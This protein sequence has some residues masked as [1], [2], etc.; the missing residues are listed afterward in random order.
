MRK[1]AIFTDI[2]G[3]LEPLEAVLKNIKEKQ[4]DE[5][6]SLGDNIGVGPNSKEVM[7]LLKKNKVVS[8]AGNAEDYVALGIEPFSYIVG[9]KKESYLWTLSQLTKEQKQ[10]LTTYP[11]SIEL[12]LG[13]KRIG[14]CHFASDVRFDYK[15][16]NVWKYQ[17]NLKRNKR[18]YKQFLYTNS[19]RQRINMQRKM[20]KLGTDSLEAKGLISA[21]NEPLF[22][23][24][25]VT[26]F[27][28]IFQ[29]HA[30]FPLYEE[31]KN[32]KFYTLRALGMAYKNDATDLAS[33]VLLTEKTSGFVIEEVLV[34]FNRDKMLDT[35]QRSTFRDKRIYKYVDMKE[36]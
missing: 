4:I 22:H 29:G 31:S 7:E 13:G 11:H 26:D 30:H 8:L 5:I 17:W 28:F 12:T 1:I 16:H 2:H 33:Y 23:G 6:Y 27:D 32:T 21:L 10:E 18:A 24:K 3:L 9:N 14:L 19:L 25:K 34:K 35:I 36:E 20:K 15:L